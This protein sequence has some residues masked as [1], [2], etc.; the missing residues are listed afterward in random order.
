[1][2]QWDKLK[3]LRE[4]AGMSRAALS[5][6]SGISAT[7][8]YRM[9]TGM[10]DWKK[11]EYGTLQ[12]LADAL[13]VPLA[14]IVSDASP[15][16]ELA[17]RL[18]RLSRKELAILKNNVGKPFTE[19]DARA[20]AVFYRILPSD[21]LQYDTDCTVGMW[22]Q[23]ICIAAA[24]TSL[25][26]RDGRLTTLPEALHLIALDDTG[27]QELEDSRIARRA[28]NALDAWWGEDGATARLVYN[29]VRLAVQDGY[30]L[31]YAALINDIVRWNDENHPVTREWVPC[32]FGKLRQEA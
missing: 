13:G 32:I 16:V 7:H 12:A 14:D 9:E 15:P 8:I 22:F 28:A 11:V 3:Q 10:R 20:L 19:A 5:E 25:E 6:A 24:G 2:A 4:A 23:A 17:G 27:E 26:D 1:M 31:D 30:K 21:A 29:L 18:S